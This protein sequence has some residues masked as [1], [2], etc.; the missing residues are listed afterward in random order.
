MKSFSLGIV[1]VPVYL[2]FSP[3]AQAAS[4][5][6]PVTQN[7]AEIAAQYKWDF[8]PICGSWAE[9][10]AAMRTIETQMNELVT[11]MEAEAAKIH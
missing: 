5:P 4:A 6:Q 2:L 3:G 9:W 1:A 10:D 11:Q 8:S 7:R